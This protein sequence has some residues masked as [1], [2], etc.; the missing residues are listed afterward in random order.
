MEYVISSPIGPLILDGD[1]HALHAIRFGGSG[2]PASLPEAPCAVLAQAARELCEYFDGTRKTFTIPLSPT[3]TPFQQRCWAALQAIPYGQT[4]S[5][6]DIAMSVG[7]PRAT[8]AVGMAN[9]RN[10]LA[11][12]IPCH[13]VI[14]KNGALGGYGGGL[15]IKEYLLSFER[16]HA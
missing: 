14:Q 2:M 10:P 8:R 12:I 15:P 11:I 7:N 16:Q 9:H 5:Y 6:A 4:V 3:G 13:R 1:E